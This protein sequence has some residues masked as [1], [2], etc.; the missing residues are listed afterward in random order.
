M[1]TPGNRFPRCRRIRTSA[2]YQR[3]RQ[4]GKRRHTR[5]FIVYTSFCENGPARLGLTV[6]RKVGRAVTRNRVK[7]LVREFFR[8][9]QSHISAGLEISVVAKPG[10]AQ[11]DFR[12]IC[13]E[14]MFLTRQK[15]T[16]NTP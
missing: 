4:R 8:Q 16:D 6:S 13:D 1:E 3:L 14:L 7:R 10:A 9:H 2:E 11:L 12:Q 5:N 15:N